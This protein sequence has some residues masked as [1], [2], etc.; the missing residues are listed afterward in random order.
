MSF[1][2]GFPTENLTAVR[3]HRPTYGTGFNTIRNLASP[4]AFGRWFDRS[5][6]LNVIGSAADTE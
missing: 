6:L 3:P 2:Y 1:E 4:G 5:A